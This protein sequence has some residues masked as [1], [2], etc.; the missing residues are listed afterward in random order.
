MS[1]RVLLLGLLLFNSYFIGIHAVDRVY[2]VGAVEGYW[3]Y[4]PSGSNIITGKNI[5]NGRKQ[6]TYKVK[7]HVCGPQR[8][9]RVYKKAF[10]KEFTDKTFTTQ[11]KSPSWLG[12]TGPILRGEVDD[13]IVIHFKNLATK[14]YTMHPHGVFYEKSSEGAIYNDGTAGEDKKD[15]KV[16]PGGTHTYKWEVHQRTGPT[17]DGSNC[18]PW[19]YHSHYESVSEEAAGLVGTILACRKGTLTKDGRSRQDI[20]REFVLLFTVTDENLSVYFDDNFKEFVDDESVNK[21]DEN[22]MQ[23]NMMDNINGYMYGNT[24]GL[25]LC[26]GDTADWHVMVFGTEQDIHTLN[27]NGNFL[28]FRG[29]RADGLG[30]SPG[31]MVTATMFASN[32]GTWLV[33]SGVT[34]HY[35]A[36]SLALYTVNEN[37]GLKQTIEKLSGVVRKYYI[38][39]E[40]VE[41]NYAP[42]G[43]DMYNGGNLTDPEKDSAHFFEQSNTRI[44]GTYYKTRYFAYTDE[45]FTMKIDPKSGEE[46]MGILGPAIRAEVGDTIEVMFKNMASQPLSIHPHGVFYDKQNEGQLYGTKYST[47]CSSVTTNNTCAY[48]WTVPEYVGPTENDGDCL[49][50]MY[51]S[52]VDIQMDL[53]TGLVGPLVVCRPGTLDATGMK[54]TKVDRE[55]FLFFTTFDENLSHL[56][57]ENVEFCKEPGAVDLDDPDFISSNQMACEYCTLMFYYHD[58]HIMLYCLHISYILPNFDIEL[59]DHSASFACIFQKNF[60]VN[61]G[62]FWSCD[63]IYTLTHCAHRASLPTLPK[64]GDLNGLTF[65]ESNYCAGETIMW[66]LMDLGKETDENT[67]YFHGHTFFNDGSRSDT[68]M[69]FPGLYKTITMETSKIGKWAIES[70]TYDH[71]KNGMQAMYTVNDCPESNTIKVEFTGVDRVHYIAAIEQEWDYAEDMYDG[72]HDISLVDSRSNGYIFVNRGDTFI[73]HKYKKAIF[74]EFTDSTFTTEIPRNP[75]GIHLGILGP[76]LRMNVGDRLRVVFKNLASFPRRYSFHAHGASYD[77][78]TEGALYNDGSYS[79]GDGI[80]PGESYTYQWVVPSTAGPSEDESTCKTWAYYSSV[81][82][83]R[84][85]N[86]GLIGPL[87]IC[88]PDTIAIDG[89]RSDVDREFAVLFTVMDENKS[90]YL[91]ENINTYCFKPEEVDVEDGDFEES[92]LMHGINGRIYGNLRG[93]EMTVNQRVD[94]YIIGVGN[95]V[96]VHSVHF[97]GQTAIYKH[98]TVQNVDVFELY[99]GVFQTM[100]MV[101]DDPGQWLLHC[102]VNDHLAAGMETTYTVYYENPIAGEEESNKPVGLIIST[103]ILATACVILVIY[104]VFMSRTSRENHKESTVYVNRSN[105][106]F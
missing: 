4:A 38:S 67:V 21:E 28:E 94:W 5:I 50:W 9:G 86:S 70:Q 92:N 88:R 82:P 103:S 42:S 54:N 104:I 102:H 16:E 3:D 2:Y 18:I 6:F 11:V 72:I 22:F 14:P 46:H 44:G 87:I 32:P 80:L 7:I 45:S 48:S 98:A 15:D 29:R 53:F 66:H 78:T 41:W 8:I 75:D 36:G 83:V 90:W 31:A 69:L 89:S 84:D 35:T 27:F 59:K 73:G 20:D 12:F 47:E 106:K 105:P 79:K 25:D 74:R 34:T 24:P 63:S 43:E 56:L 61:G 33:D 49:S 26:Y 30:V 81:D 95:E 55:Y 62:V 13:V 64:C 76:I 1:S 37:C 99:P 100:E 71:F 52:A 51:Y 91:E 96:D 97:H 57:A 58:Y 19:V 17:K 40:T 77:K 93:I 101:A 23:S 68:V 10:Y 65:P 60:H 39:A 85:I